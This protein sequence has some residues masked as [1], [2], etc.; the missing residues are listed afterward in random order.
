MSAWDLPSI[1][2]EI[3]TYE[4]TVL[5]SEGA[6]VI[7]R[8]IQG[9]MMGDVTKQHCPNF[10]AML[11]RRPY[12]FF[13]R[14]LCCVGSMSGGT[15]SSYS[16][17][18]L[19]LFSVPAVLLI[20]VSTCSQQFLPNC[21]FCSYVIPILSMFFLV[22]PCPYLPPMFFQ[23]LHSR[24]VLLVVRILLSFPYRLQQLDKTRNPMCHNMDI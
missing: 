21:V 4:N 2:H 13:S 1:R 18:V 12:R 9:M 19:F 10:N 8:S 5:I 16:P 11:I 17:H 7:P 3:G 14:N 24:Y 22:C 6:Y 23:F 15:F 20:I